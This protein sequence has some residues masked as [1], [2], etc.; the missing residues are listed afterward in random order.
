MKL[1][2]IK[3]K[4]EIIGKVFSQRFDHTPRTECDGGT[5][6]D[7]CLNCDQKFINLK[8]IFIG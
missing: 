2:D 3:N 7:A 5:E 6:C 1:S 8:K 4:N